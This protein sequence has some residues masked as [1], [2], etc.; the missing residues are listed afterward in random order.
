MFAQRGVEGTTTE[1]SGQRIDLRLGPI[2]LDRLGQPS[3]QLDRRF[4][5]FHAGDDRVEDLVAQVLEHLRR[6]AQPRR[7]GNVPRAR[8]GFPPPIKR[9]QQGSPIEAATAA[10]R[11][12]TEQ[13]AAK[14]PSV[15]CHIGDVAG[16]G[17]GP[18]AAEGL[19]CRAALGWRP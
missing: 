3:L 6:D 7:D 4:P 19:P 12:V 14:D 9:R 16:P 8:H 1:Q 2:V 15:S 11:V 5:A 13:I 18:G 17:G 10:T